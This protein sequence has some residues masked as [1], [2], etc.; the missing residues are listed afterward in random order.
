MTQQFQK[1][2][3]VMTHPNARKGQAVPIQN[4]RVKDYAG[5]PDF[6]PP[7]TVNNED[8]EERHA[9]MGYRPAGMADPSAYSQ[10]V[11]A[12]QPVGFAPQEYPKWVNGTLVNDRDEEEAAGGGASLASAKKAKRDAAFVELANKIDADMEAVKRSERA[13]RSAATR[14]ANAAKVSEGAAA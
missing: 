14:K 4:G 3:M 5:V 1:Y 9:A 10:Q 6:M 7:V 13:K 8:Q 12:P 11:V 2:P